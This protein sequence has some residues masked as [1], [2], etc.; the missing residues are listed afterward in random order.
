MN[1]PLSDHHLER[2]VDEG[3]GTG[4]KASDNH[5]RNQTMKLEGQMAVY[6]KSA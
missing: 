5:T 2:E 4:H 1:L 6:R 3:Q